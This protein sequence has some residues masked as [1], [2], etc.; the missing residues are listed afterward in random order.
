MPQRLRYPELVPDG[1]AALSGLEH[2]LNVGSGLEPVLLEF[3]RLR[4]SQLN[5]CEYCVGLHSAELRKH[6]EPESRIAAIAAWQQSDAFTQRERA[7]LRWAEVITNVQDG[8]AADAEFESARKH[9]TDAELVN[10]TLALA[11]I[12]AWNRM[13]IA[14]RPQWREKAPPVQGEESSVVGDDGGKAAVDD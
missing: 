11:S 4:A 14:F 9:F 8:H 12:N 2:Y 1:V 6:H 13:A 10:L 3:I 5:G 7:G